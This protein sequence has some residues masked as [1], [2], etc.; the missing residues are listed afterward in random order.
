MVAHSNIF[1]LYPEGQVSILAPTLNYLTPSNSQIEL[2]FCEKWYIQVVLLKS[3]L[4]AHALI[5]AHSPV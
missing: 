4:E 2:L 5:E 1:Q 3:L